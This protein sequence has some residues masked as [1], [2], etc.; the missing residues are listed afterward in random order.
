MLYS[1]LKKNQNV[2]FPTDSWDKNDS[3]LKINEGRSYFLNTELNFV[4]KFIK[5]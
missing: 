5:L 1:W 2:I 3:F 4:E